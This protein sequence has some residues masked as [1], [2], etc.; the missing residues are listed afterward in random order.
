MKSLASIITLSAAM[1]TAAQASE[2]NQVQT[3]VSEI[4]F[5]YTQ[6]GVTMR[7]G[8]SRFTAEL[9]FDPEQLDQAYV[10]ID[11]DLASIDTGIRE[12]DTEVT[13][14][15]WLHTAEFPTARFESNDVTALDEHNYTV[16][17]N[18]TIKGTTQ[19]ISVPATF[20]AENGVGVFTG[21]FR[22]NRGDF[23]IGEGAWASFDMVANAIKVEFQM[24][25]TVGD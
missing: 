4:R 20:A 5:S 23:A 18:L 16:S 7:G 10:M 17:G 21:A 9:R 15:A 3:E 2:Y 11:V 1:I 13:K 14:P 24:T 12:A 19:E 22:I 6:M 25:A 8:F